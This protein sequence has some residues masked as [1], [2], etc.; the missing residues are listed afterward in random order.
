MVERRA[1]PRYPL[2]LAAEMT[3]EDSGTKTTARTG[4]VSRNGCYIDTLNP[5]PAGTI[6]RLRLTQG[7]ETFETRA[8]VIYEVPSMGMGLQFLN[9]AAKQQAILN[10]WLAEAAGN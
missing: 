8:R 4:D 1:G 3:I 2:I 5:I 6:L 7:G 9:V 10:C